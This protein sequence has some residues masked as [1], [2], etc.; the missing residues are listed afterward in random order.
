M[1]RHPLTVLAQTMVIFSM[2]TQASF[3]TL[4]MAIKKRSKKRENFFLGQC[5]GFAIL[6]WRNPRLFI[7]TSGAVPFGAVS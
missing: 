3:T 4:P 6:I 1:D 5:A 7:F 2:A